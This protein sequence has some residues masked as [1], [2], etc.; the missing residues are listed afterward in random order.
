MWKVDYQDWSRLK[1]IVGD[2]YPEN[3]RKKLKKL[4]DVRIIL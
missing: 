4:I 3:K 1:R 2:D